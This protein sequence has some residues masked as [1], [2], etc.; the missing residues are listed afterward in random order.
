M[1]KK[2][3]AED[4]KASKFKKTAA[5][6]AAPVAKK[7]SGLR[8][9]ASLIIY[10]LLFLLLTVGMF[11]L[12]AL[13]NQRQA[14]QNQV[15]QVASNLNI[16][17][18][19]MSRD[20][21]DLHI[22][23][24]DEL[25]KHPD[26][27]WVAI[28]A[29]PQK[30]QY[31][32]DDLK[33]LR[34][35][36]DNDLNA[37]D[38]GGVITNYL[39][40]QEVP[41]TAMDVEFKA[42]ENLDNA[43]SVWHLYRGLMDSL[44]ADAD[45]LGI[46]YEKTSVFLVDYNRQYSSKLIFEVEGI[47]NAFAAVSSKALKDF[48][49]IELGA[50]IAAV[51]LFLFIV[52]GALRQLFKNDALLD[53]ANQ[54]MNE[55]MGSVNE[56]LF[57][58]DRDLVIGNEY[59]ARLEG[60]IGRKDIAGASLLDI[61]KGL[62]SEEEL[63]TTQTF[64]DQLYSEWVVEDLIDDL[65]PLNRISVK[66]PQTQEERFLDFK[67]YRVTQNNEIVRVLVNVTDTTEIVKLQESQR[68]Q[69]EQE[70]QELEM[71]NIILNTNP[72]VLSS[73]I[74]E[75]QNKLEEINRALKSQ[76]TTQRELKEK[77]HH[78]ARLIHGV[79]GEASSIKLT[80]MVSICETFEESL[81]VMKNAH[82]LRG[83]DFLGLVV[84]LEDLFRLFDILEGYNRRLNMGAGGAAMMGS[85]V[86]KETQAEYFRKFVQDIAQRTGKQVHLVCEGFDDI[87]LSE[88]LQSKLRSIAVQL[89]RNAMIHGI[90]SPQERRARNKEEAGII[91]L[92]L[93]Q[94][95]NDNIMLAIED[96]GNGINFDAIRQK[97]LRHGYSEDAVQNMNQQQLYNLMFS[98]GFSTADEQ[99]EDAGRGV[100]MDIIKATVKEMGGRINIATQ[101]ESYTRFKFIFPKN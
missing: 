40:G 31:R 58:V 8:K 19:E 61:L 36:F 52:F 81:E 48:E 44:A 89:L 97:A 78:I 1:A 6:K 95:S 35:I 4:K 65:N 94:D 28:S 80:R 42:R 17:V 14:Q 7:K 99:T 62:V 63:E 88:V 100:G 2:K 77:V 59:S 96:D 39:T 24:E 38:K 93:S 12:N 68:S 46:L 60:I 16:I 33:T 90:E 49:L 15:T 69:R 11:S 23:V 85:F 30:A 13:F 20:I 25:D 54:E 50:I 10:I 84:W 26:R 29:L 51:L 86:E 56:G 22:Y 45:Q 9:Y 53:L 32:L 41:I 92:S 70:G 21:M 71:L 74:R 57:L 87:Q 66:N 64:I 75:S 55:I 98:S 76:S 27:D 47:A 73:F 37:F 79:K 91:R 83:Q 3:K 67:F 43:L 18:Q 82:I 5:K 72:M 101:A 34:N